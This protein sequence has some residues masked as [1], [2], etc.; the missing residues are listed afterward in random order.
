[1]ASTALRN[2]GATSANLEPARAPSAHSRV[3]SRIE[4]GSHSERKIWSIPGA[5]AACLLPKCRVQEV[6]QPNARSLEPIPDQRDMLF[7][8]R[9]IHDDHPLVLALRNRITSLRAVSLSS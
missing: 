7:Q 2:F 1:M 8:I 5:L 3:E 4:K 6:P 9:G